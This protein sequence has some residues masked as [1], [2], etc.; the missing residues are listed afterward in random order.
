M[1]MNRAA[2]LGIHPVVPDLERLLELAG[3]SN[4]T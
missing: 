3:T 4:G 2:E 1:A